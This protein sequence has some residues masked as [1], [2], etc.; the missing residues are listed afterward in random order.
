MKALFPQNDMFGLLPIPLRRRC[1]RETLT[2][3]HESDI[4]SKRYA[5]I[6]AY[7]SAEKLQLLG[8][9]ESA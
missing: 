9:A 1:N 8:L 7:Y 4:P 2:K 5:W 6:V 3:A